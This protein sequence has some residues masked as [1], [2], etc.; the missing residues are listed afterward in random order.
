MR[1]HS[2]ALYLTLVLI[3]VIY[4]MCMSLYAFT[5]QQKPSPDQ[6]EAVTGG[7]DKVKEEMR[8]GSTGQTVRVVWL[9]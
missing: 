7:M 8:K 3:V 2:T 4:I 1:K 9:Q 6:Q 5:A